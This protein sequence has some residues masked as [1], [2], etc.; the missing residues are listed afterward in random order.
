MATFLLLGIAAVCIAIFIQRKSPAWIGRNGEKYVSEKLYKLDPTHYKIHNDIMLLSKGNSVATQIDHIVV[1]NYGIFCIE[2]KAYKGWIFG[3]ANQDQWTQV[4]FRYKG[5]FYNPLRQNFAH[6]S[7]IKDLL[8]AQR[9]KKPV[10]SLIVFSVADKLK[11]SGTDSVGYAR[12]IVRKIGSYTEP[13]FSDAERDEIYN[14]IAA[15]NII[16]KE[17]RNLHIREVRNLK[18]CR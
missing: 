2:T 15:A 1:S 9:L 7:A 17:A 18:L 12:D 11:I 16:N 10:V 14:L 5:R 4:I 8:G 3:N 6:I 13:V